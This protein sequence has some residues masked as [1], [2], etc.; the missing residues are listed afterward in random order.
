[1][2]Q[3]L[4]LVF[5]I[6]AFAVAFAY[7]QWLRAGKGDAINDEGRL[8]IIIGAAAGA[9]A[10]SRILGALEDPAQI[11]WTWSSVLVALGNRTIVGALLG[12]LIGV[13][14]TK[15]LIGVR[16]SSGDL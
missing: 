15:R 10:G 5:E 8:W 2:G 13:E 1:M 14:L 16:T 12:G 6:G 3:I 11:T 4:H 7:Y 9:L